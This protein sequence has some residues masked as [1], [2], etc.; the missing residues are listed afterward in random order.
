MST[1]IVEK[2]DLVKVSVDINGILENEAE[3]V[4]FWL[5]EVKV[6]VKW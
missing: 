3:A 4:T 2:E 1:E 6:L 5:E